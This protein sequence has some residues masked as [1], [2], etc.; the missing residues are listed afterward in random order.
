MQIAAIAVIGFGFL[1]SFLRRYAYSSLGLN[2]LMFCIIILESVIVLGLLRH[3]VG[4]QEIPLD[5]ELILKGQYCAVA[6]VISFGA[7]MGR[8]S[9]HQLLWLLV[10]EVPFYA[11]N[12]LL[13]GQL[14]PIAYNFSGLKSLDI[15]G[16]LYMHA[17]GTYYGLTASFLF[18]KKGGGSTHP[19][20]SSTY[21]SDILV[22]IG[23]FVLWILWP[24]MNSIW[25]NS[26]NDSFVASMNTVLAAMGACIATFLTSIYI[27]N[28]IDIMHVQNGTLAGGV[29]M[30][31]GASL[32]MM[33]GIAILIGAIAGVI[34]TISLQHINTFLEDRLKIED[35]RAVHDLHGIPGLIGGLVVVFT[36][37]LNYSGNKTLL[38]THYAGGD[39][40]WHELLAILVTL[41]CAIVGGFISGVVIRQF[42]F[43]TSLTSVAYEDGA[44]WQD[45]DPEEEPMEYEAIA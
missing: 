22:M 6:G 14:N 20:L 4:F 18:S 34:C 3:G 28:K 24:T 37:I 12:L 19:K 38:D 11:L 16:G 25:T 17:F 42:D 13:I 40:W 26:Y 35:T 27:A 36:T 21:D 39:T 31:A 41:V 45:V 15:G 23:T 1:S 2:Y 8:V 29:V 44:I 5:F 9:P 33:P 30:A 43:A 10:L 7:I 32:R